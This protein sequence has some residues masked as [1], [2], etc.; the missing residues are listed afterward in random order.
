HVKSTGGSDF[1]AMAVPTPEADNSLPL[2]G[3]IVIHEIF[4]AP[5]VG[6]E[7]FIE[8]KNVSDAPVPLFDP[9]AP[10][11][12]WQ[13]TDGITFTFPTGANAV[14]MAPD[15][16]I[17]VVPNDPTAFRAANGVPANI[18]IFGSH[19]TALNNGGE[20]LELSKPGPAEPDGTI[21][22]ILVDRVNYDNVLPWPLEAAG[23]G[24]ALQRRVA[25][26]YGN[27][28]GNWAA[29][30]DGGTPGIVPPQVTGVFVSGSDWSAEFIELL[31]AG[32]LD[33][34]GFAIRTG[35]G[36]F[37]ALPW[38]GID[39]VSIRFSRDMTVTQADL[40]LWGVN[41][42]QLPVA[43]FAYDN[44]QRIA[45]W[46]LESPL[47][48][49][50]LLI[51]LSSDVHDVG[52]RGLDADWIDGFSTFPSGNDF[53]E[54]DERFRFRINVLPGN[55]DAGPTVDRADLVEAIH[56]LGLGAGD[57]AYD[58]LHDL[59]GDAQI[60][61]VDLRELLRRLHT[62]LP[63]S[64]PSP[65]QA[66]S[67]LIAVDTVFARLGAASPA[68]AAVADQEPS[69]AIFPPRRS[70]AGESNLLG[71][72]S[73]RSRQ[74]LATRRLSTGRTHRSNDAPPANLAVD[75]AMSELDDLPR[76]R[77]ATSSTARRPVAAES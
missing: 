50:A 52:G 7:E 14:T 40:T 6:R 75:L 65:D 62:R 53:V 35:N 47:R 58:P 25:D 49:D 43:G 8:L 34:V 10:Q 28:P 68:A 23:G 15:E 39:Q 56:H 76:T 1:T 17:L 57:A 31:S 32:R 9:A 18:R 61:L 74:R 55:V 37:D 38:T 45:T 12:A 22:L 21:P 5:P 20:S 3:P 63:S 16:T 42:Q 48:A 30:G 44:A 67:P 77:R 46:T 70:T 69:S 71:E 19:N 73:R 66:S 59:T 64:E 11:N 29:S 27:D 2:V 51:D 4:Y 36:Q 24:A 33:A 41:R 26:A 13:F 60:D 72:I 54:G